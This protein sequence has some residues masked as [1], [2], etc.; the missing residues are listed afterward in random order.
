MRLYIPPNDANEEYKGR[1]VRRIPQ[2]QYTAIAGYIFPPLVQR[3]T[4][5]TYSNL[6]SWARKMRKNRALKLSGLS[7]L[8][9]QGDNCPGKKNFIYGISSNDLSNIIE[10]NRICKICHDSISCDCSIYRAMT[11]FKYHAIATY[12][13]INQN[14]FTNNTNVFLHF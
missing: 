2:L 8:V 1:T 4:K 11:S 3:V 9:Y 5:S 12:Q 10:I 14:L 13:C 6:M 7:L